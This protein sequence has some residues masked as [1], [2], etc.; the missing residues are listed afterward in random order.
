MQMR[1]AAVLSAHDMGVRVDA[2]DVL[3]GIAI[4][5]PSGAWWC[6]CGPNGA[7]KSTLL[8][9]LAGLQAHSGRVSLSG[10]PWSDQH[11]LQRAMHLAWMGQA[12]P[13]P[14]DLTVREVALLGRWPHGA[15]GS[16]SPQL[17]Q[18][19]VDEVLRD[20]G[21][22]DLAHRALGQLSGGECQR[23]LLARALAVRARV[24]L[25][26]EPLNHLDLPH[27]QACLQSLRRACADG[28]AAITVMDELQHALAADVLL[29]MQ[30]GR[31]LHQGV[32]GDARTREALQEA[33][34]MR[35]SFHA[36]DTHGTGQRWVV[37]PGPFS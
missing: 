10:Q 28:S 32:P 20:L 22:Q 11:P 37:L 24:L 14:H 27:Q 23:A 13:V 16:S 9:A 5:L 36:I 4:D 8:R 21:L 30:Q 34:G 31:V 33:F 17:D 2:R 3:S 29:V 15:S 26:D 18:R 12:Q 6:V 19:V 7:G 35:L 1:S 25:L